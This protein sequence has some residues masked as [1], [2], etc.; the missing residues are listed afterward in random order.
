MDFEFHI[1]GVME[2]IVSSMILLGFLLCC[3]AFFSGSET[4]MFS[5][6]P[7]R[8]HHLEKEGLTL[9]DFEAYCETKILMNRIKDHIADEKGIEDYFYNN[10]A[11][12][13]QARISC[14]I[15]KNEN[16]ANEIIMQVTEEGEDFHA[17][18]RKYSEDGQ[19]KYSGGYVGVISREKLP[20]E[21]G[22]KVFNASPGDVLGPFQKDGLFQLLLVEEI[23]K[24]DINDTNI[25][26]IIKERIFNE[27][28]S[29]FIKE[30]I[31][32]NP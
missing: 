4:A 25:K 27:W 8:I 28:A 29:Q 1:C 7:I 6:N 13:D 12:L 21:V 31:K 24:A 20:P 16:L 32:V 22:A 11:A 26:D 17:L 23:T 5:L 3:S 2:V 15:V 14:I 10:R 9:D 19:S 30:G 18:A